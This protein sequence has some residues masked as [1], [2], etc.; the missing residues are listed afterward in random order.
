MSSEKN[1]SA[2]FN[3][4]HNLNGLKVK[5]SIKDYMTSNEKLGYMGQF[6]KK[7]GFEK[8]VNIVIRNREFIKCLG[9]FKNKN[10]GESAVFVSESRENQALRKLKSS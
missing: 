6:F 4:K 9:H 7:E 5:N 10:K 3:I 1:E 8:Q 2:P